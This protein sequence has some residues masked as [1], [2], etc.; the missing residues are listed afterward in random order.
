MYVVLYET[1]KDLASRPLVIKHS[2]HWNIPAVVKAS[3]AHISDR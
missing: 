3:P 2:R 1:L